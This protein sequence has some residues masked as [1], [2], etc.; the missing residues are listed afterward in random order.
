MPHRA[1]YQR[2][3]LMAAGRE[4]RERVL[5]TSPREKKLNFKRESIMNMFGL[6]SPEPLVVSATKSTQVK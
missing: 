2:G 3:G 6:L 1:Y 5:R 4:K